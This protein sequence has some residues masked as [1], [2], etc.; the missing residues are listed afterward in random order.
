MNLARASNVA[1]AERLTFRLMFLGESL[2]FPPKICSCVSPYQCESK[3]KTTK[4]VPA[5]AETSIL[6]TAK[7]IYAT[8]LD[9]RT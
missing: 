3:T 4:K 1:K 2:N 7:K 6:Q 9:C 8:D 5:I